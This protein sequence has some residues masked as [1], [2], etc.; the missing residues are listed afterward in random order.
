MLEVEI[1]GLADVLRKLET[2]PAEKVAAVSKATLETLILV[3]SQAKRDTPW[4]TGRLRA[5]NQLQ[6]DADRLGGIVFNDVD[7]AGYVHNGTRYVK[8]RPFLYN[9]WQGEADH[10]LDKLKAIFS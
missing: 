3:Q 6:M 4:K 8:P 9:A 10:Y 1:A 7:Y 5:A 2:F